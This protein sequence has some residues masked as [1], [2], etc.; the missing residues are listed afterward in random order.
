MSLI[1]ILSCFL[2]LDVWSIY[3][4]HSMQAKINYLMGRSKIEA[5][6]ITYLLSSLRAINIKDKENDRQR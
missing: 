6:S 2:V 3:K 1:I 4:I 5:E